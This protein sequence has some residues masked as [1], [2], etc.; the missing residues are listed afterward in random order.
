MAKKSKKKYY[1]VVKPFTYK[2]KFHEVGTKIY[3][4]EKN[5]EVLIN[6]NLIK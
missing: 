4:D 1:K 3:L 6:I 2:G 5:K